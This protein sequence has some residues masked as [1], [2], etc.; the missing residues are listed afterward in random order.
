[1][2]KIKLILNILLS[3]GFTLALV[4]AWDTLGEYVFTLN[5]L[6]Q[7]PIGARLFIGLGAAVFAINAA[8][9]LKQERGLAV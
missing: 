7:A 5:I 4:I 3:I 1:M 6:P 2:R 9:L 8:L